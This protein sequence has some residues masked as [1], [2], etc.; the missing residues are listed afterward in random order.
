M[1]L[2]LVVLDLL[3]FRGPAFA[4]IIYN[5]AVFTRAL[6]CGTVTFPDALSPLPAHKQSTP[7]A[8][9][10]PPPK[11]S[12]VTLLALTACLLMRA[13]C[14]AMAWYAFRRRRRDRGGRGLLMR[15]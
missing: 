7:A 8:I 5:R 3:L 1:P 13:V 4:H 12:P 6:T 10:P 9:P 14:A 2:L 15:W 11:R